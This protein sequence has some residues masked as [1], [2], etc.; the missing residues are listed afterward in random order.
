[1]GSTSASDV[2]SSLWTACGRQ[3]SVSLMH[4]SNEP[5]P[6]ALHISRGYPFDGSPPQRTF[7]RARVMH[8]LRR[9]ANPARPGP[10]PWPLPKKQPHIAPAEE[11]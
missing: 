2:N 11:W 7:D 4:R 6:S 5:G 9:I 1:M 10:G 8:I 3:P